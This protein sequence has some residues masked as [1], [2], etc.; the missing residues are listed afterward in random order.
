MAI[1]G[2][3]LDCEGQM[4]IEENLNRLQERYG[5][6]EVVTLPADDWGTTT[7]VA[8]RDVGKNELQIDDRTHYSY[9]W[10]DITS[11]IIN[12]T[13]Y[14]TR[15]TKSPEFKGDLGLLLDGDGQFLGIWESVAEGGTYLEFREP[16]TADMVGQTYT[17]AAM[18]EMPV[19]RPMEN[20]YLPPAEAVTDA[21]GKTPRTYLRR[22]P[23][24]SKVQKIMPRKQSD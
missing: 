10:P 15:Y 18:R 1:K 8:D 23:R 24:R 11:V 2:G 4:E 19:V 20:K 13:E 3:L 9:I 22:S 14:P 17:V 12:G 7:D 6:E 21:A 5:Y 16:I